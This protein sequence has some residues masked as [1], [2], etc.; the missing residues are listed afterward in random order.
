MPWGF[1]LDVQLHNKNRLVLPLSTGELMPIGK[2]SLLDDYFC[3]V[4]LESLCE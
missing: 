2:S 1:D 4:V 3:G